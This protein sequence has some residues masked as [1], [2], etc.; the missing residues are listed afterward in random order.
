MSTSAVHRARPRA[1]ARRRRACR[2]VGQQ[3]RAPPL[4]RARR[5]VPRPADDGPR[6]D[7]RERRAAL[8]PARPALLPGQ[9]H[10]GD[11][12]LPDHLRRLPAARR[13]GRRPDR[14]QARV[15]DRARPVHRRVGA[16]RDRQQPGAADRRPPAAGSRRR[17]RLERDPGDHRDR[18]PGQGRAG[19]GDG[20]VRVRVRRRRLD[21]PARRRRADA[22]ARLA[23]D[24]LRQRA[25]RRAR[26][27]ARIG[28]DR[29][30]RGHRPRRR[31]GRA[32]LDPDHAR[33]HARRLR[34]RQV[35]RIRAALGAH[36][37]RRRRLAGAARRVPRARGAPGQPDHA[38]ADPAAAHADGLEPR[39][40]PARHR[41]VLGVLPRLAVSRARARLQRDRHRPGVHAV[42]RVDRRDVD[43]RGGQGG[44]ALRCASTRW[45]RA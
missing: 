8:H 37:R 41:D 33:D 18:V 11:R 35:D 13:P 27:P 22:V 6:R 19:Q 4:D 32:R 16:V 1:D 2:R 43:G 30:E 3:A 14:A 45:R 34:D 21:R 42:D 15:P 23:L 44:R 26:V 5:A 31:R 7:D 9:P 24:L 29:G 39:A 40:R 38:A 20:P 17:G 12:R 36:A 10:V 28:A 25:D